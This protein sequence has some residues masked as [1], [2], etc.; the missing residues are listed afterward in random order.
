MKKSYL[1]IFVIVIIFGFVGSGYFFVSS[2]KASIEEDS[3][4]FQTRINEITDRFNKLIM[5]KSENDKYNNFLDI[6]KGIIK[7]ETFEKEDILVKEMNNFYDEIKEKNFKEFNKELEDLKKVNLKSLSDKNKE[8]VTNI[9]ENVQKAINE[10]DFILA[11]D[12]IEKFKNEVKYAK[13]NKDNEEI[14]KYLDLAEKNL[15]DGKITEAN[16]ELNNIDFE[17]LNNEN[18]AIYNEIKEKLDNITALV[19]ISGKYKYVE[20]SDKKAP[21]YSVELEVK[22]TKDG[23]ITIKGIE[24]LV[25]EIKS[26]EGE[27]IQLE[28]L[29]TEMIDSGKAVIKEY[30]I[31]GNLKKKDGSVEEFT[32]TIKRSSEEKRETEM[33]V[34]DNSIE[35]NLY[36]KKIILKK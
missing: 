11:K 7:D 6:S 15:N 19:N 3:K 33:V 32:G 17:S 18:K 25:S 30:D 22:A 24:K 14:R 31:T 2:K 8:Q 4:A 13:E 34:F 16:K 27:F 36:G 1:I 28:D 5:T 26:V 20:L 29:T 23:D 10:S 35:L 9:L 21:K 12:L